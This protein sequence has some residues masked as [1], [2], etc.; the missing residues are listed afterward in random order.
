MESQAVDIGL[1]FSDCIDASGASDIPQLN[2]RIPAARDEHPRQLWV[3]GDGTHVVGMAA[4]Y[5][6]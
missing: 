4:E 2:G 3:E 5:F 1:V 6:G